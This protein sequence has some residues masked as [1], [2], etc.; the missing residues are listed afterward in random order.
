LG[1]I[2][3][4]VLWV[5]VAM[6]TLQNLGVEVTAL[7][8]GLG[9]GGIAVALA[10]QNILGDLFASMSIVLDKPFVLGDF[11]VVDD[12]MGTVEKIGLK[13]TRLRSLGGE[14]LIFPNNK[15]LQS[16]IR[17]HKRMTERRVQFTVGVAYETPRETLQRIPTIVRDA[18]EAQPETRFDRA[19]F[20]SFGPSSLDF[21][22]VYFVLK[23]DHRIYMDIQ[24]AVN[25]LL[26]D[27]FAAEKIQFAY[28]TQT[29]HVRTTNT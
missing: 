29:L 25:L 17:N 20:K 27:R 2:A 10:A 28:P 5:I 12:A 11:I 16:R 21:E 19:H 24:Q 26:L 8:A 15:L 1:F 23:P 9:V 6:L 22:V 4:I 3:K 18:I 13:T 14:Q 7:V